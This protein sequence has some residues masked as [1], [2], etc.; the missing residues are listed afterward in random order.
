[1]LM[2]NDS[3]NWPFTKAVGALPIMQD[4]GPGEEGVST[5]GAQ[6]LFSK[7]LDFDPDKGRR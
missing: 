4:Y 5:R 7:K 1:M 6:P 3:N 2:D